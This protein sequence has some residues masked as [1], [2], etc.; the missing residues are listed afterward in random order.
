MTFFQILCLLGHE[1]DIFLIFM[2]FF[3]GNILY[4]AFI[5]K[6]RKEQKD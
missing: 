3:R 5:N 1:S 4:D 2:I 6:K